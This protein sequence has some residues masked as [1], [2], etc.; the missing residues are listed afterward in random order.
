MKKAKTVHLGA[1]W[2]HFTFA[3]SFSMNAG[4]MHTFER[5]YL[6]SQLASMAFG[7]LFDFVPIACWFG[8]EATGV[9]GTLTGRCWFMGVGS[10]LRR[11]SDTNQAPPLSPPARV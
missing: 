8:P 11:C 5:L 2:G 7:N 10:Q 3:F 6:K 1:V 4:L 9:T